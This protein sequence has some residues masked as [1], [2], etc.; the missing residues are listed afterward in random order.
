M[1]IYIIYVVSAG[2][3]SRL[4]NSVNLLTRMTET[5]HGSSIAKKKTE[6]NNGIA[7][8]C[9]KQA[10]RSYFLHIRVSENT[11]SNSS[12]ILELFVLESYDVGIRKYFLFL[13]EQDGNTKQPVNMFF[14]RHVGVRCRVIIEFIDPE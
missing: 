14:M 7:K 10:N 1:V 3:A 9:G 8:R 2:K 5:Q 12:D 4:E 13:Q 11:G 6:I